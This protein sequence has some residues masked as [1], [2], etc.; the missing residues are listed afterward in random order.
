[1]N[2]SILKELQEL[3]A[4][5]V[6][7]QETANSIE[8]Y[9]RSKTQPPSNRFAIVLS[10]LGALL[11]GLGIVLVVAHNWDEFGKTAKTI[12]AFLPLVLGQ[13]LCMYTLL[14]Q[15][16]SFAWRESSAL[17]LFFGVGACIA[18]I[19]QIYHIGGSLTD[20][21]LTWM[22]LI[23]AL[24]Y[25]L[26]SYITGLLYIAGI[27]WYACLAG[28]FDH[29]E[30]QPY[31]FLPLLLLTAP[32]YLQLL[33][34]K[35]E[36][37]MF[38]LYNWFIAAAFPC[39]LGAF[40]SNNENATVGFLGYLS[41]F[42]LYYVAG[43]SSLFREKRLFANPYLIA[44][45]PGI[46]AILLFWTYRNSWIS[47]NDTPAWNTPFLYINIVLLCGLLFLLLRR[48]RIRGWQSISPVEFSS[49]VFLAAVMLTSTKTSNAAYDSYSAMPGVV[50][51]N[52]WVLALGIYFTRKGSIQQHFGILNLGL[53]IIAALALQRFF[54][55]DIPFVWRG[56]FFLAAGIGFFAA[57][58][59]LIKK[60]RSLAVKETA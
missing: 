21:V 8:T 3:V 32:A 60:K 47:F 7:S 57:N 22:L 30:Q 29:P 24:I 26:P 46:I 40:I 5:N 9:Y 23:V 52:I 34:R 42:C 6:I 16:E 14:K 58:Y 55:E 28:Y 19:S 13:A 17:I 51:I 18:L 12:L 31:L 2:P 53:L 41:L 37:N 4:A 45:I 43:T 25:V 10:I 48:Y 59:L 49:F 33:R 35:S 11:V 50:I 36:S 56:I 1:M 20:F 15:K 54:D 39:V 27:T 44:G 38:I